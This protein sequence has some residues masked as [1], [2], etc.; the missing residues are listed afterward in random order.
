MNQ[1]GLAVRI[2]LRSAEEDR[3]EAV[4]DALLALLQASGLAAGEAGLAL[5]AVGYRQTRTLD[6]V[7]LYQ[8][9]YFAEKMHRDTGTFQ[10]GTMTRLY[11]H[12]ADRWAEETGQ[13]YTP[14]QFKAAYHYWKKKTGGGLNRS[15][16]TGFEKTPRKTLVK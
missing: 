15:H 9:V 1:H 12:F 3:K 11:A 14:E 13:P 7:T 16:R 2:A 5:E 8:S 10:R 6:L 4:K